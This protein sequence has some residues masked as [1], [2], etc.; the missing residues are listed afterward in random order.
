MPNLK[1][2]HTYQAIRELIIHNLKR[3]KMDL[4]KINRAIGTLNVLHALNANTK[5]EKL[6]DLILENEISRNMW[7]YPEKLTLEDK[8]KITQYAKELEFANEAEFLQWLKFVTPNPSG[9]A[10]CGHIPGGISQ[11]DKRE[12]VGDKF[13]IHVHTGDFITQ[14][15]SEKGIVRIG[16]MGNTAGKP[17]PTWTQG[18]QNWSEDFMN[19]VSIACEY[20]MWKE[21]AYALGGLPCGQGRFWPLEDFIV[22]MK[23]EK[24]LDNAALQVLQAK[25]LS[26]IQIPVIQPSNISKEEPAKVAY[27]LEDFSDLSMQKTGR[28]PN[29]EG[30]SLIAEYLSKKLGT[31]IFVAEN[32][33]D[34]TSLLNLMA[35]DQISCGTKVG[36]IGL[37]SSGHWYALQVEKTQHNQ[38]S[39]ILMDSLGN[40]EHA[41]SAAFDEVSY[42]VQQFISRNTQFNDSVLFHNRERLQF[43]PENC[44]TYSAQFCKKMLT[45]DFLRTINAAEQAKEK[46]K[47]SDKP[48]FTRLYSLPADYYFKQYNHLGGESELVLQ[49]MLKQYKHSLQANGTIE[50]AYMTPDLGGLSDNPYYK[51]FQEIKRIRDKY[52]ENVIAQFQREMPSSQM[53]SL[54]ASRKLENVGLPQLI[55]ATQPKPVVPPRSAKTYDFPLLQ[56]VTQKMENLSI[57]P[58]TLPG[59]QADQKS[60]I[61]DIADIK[62]EMVKLGKRRNV[63]ANFAVT[64]LRNYLEKNAIGTGADEQKIYVDSLQSLTN[65]IKRGV[66]D[67]E[68][69]SLFQRIENVGTKAATLR[70]S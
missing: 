56:V 8:R 20:G 61:E 2:F 35:N 55:S 29:K 24:S 47:E 30:F 12:L 45:S 42:A 50:D 9:L 18:I 21:F 14:T 33:Q 64:Q 66:Q 40:G 13:D 54:L 48:D 19:A 49:N 41:R 53:T 28:V 7:R 6:G 5:F 60:L 3:E 43:D 27:Q 17:L 39:V 38:M 36:V 62:A 16:K 4:D 10:P 46:E 15:E 68:V 65:R 1:D 67:A 11:K 22:K 58:T 23:K 63:T 37:S 70:L 57:T 52:W 69:I 34:V 26:H 32:N 44:G 59:S 51:I 31:E 25:H